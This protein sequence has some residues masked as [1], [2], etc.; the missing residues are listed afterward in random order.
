MSEE[1]KTEMLELSIHIYTE[2]TIDDFFKLLD[3]VDTKIAFDLE[4]TGLDARKD[5]IVLAS[6]CW[7]EEVHII[8][9]D[10]NRIPEHKKYIYHNAKF[11]WQFMYQK[12]GLDLDIYSDTMVLWYNKDPANDVA[13]EDV[14]ET[15]GYPK[16]SFKK[17]FGKKANFRDCLMFDRDR[18]LQYAG[19]DVYVTLKAYKA[20][21][22]YK[23]EPLYDVDMLLIKSVAMSELW[24]I[25]LDIDYFDKQSIILDEQITAL[26]EELIRELGQ[27]SNEKFNINS[28]EQLADAL[29]IYGVP[30]TKKTGSKKG[31]AKKKEIEVKPEEQNDSKKSKKKAKPKEQFAT[32]EDVL[33]KFEDS[34]PVVKKLLHYKALNKLKNSFFDALPELLDDKNMLH[35]SFKT[36]HTATGRFSSSDPNLQQLPNPDKSVKKT[37]IN[38]RCG[39]IPRSGYYFL[40]ADFN[41]IEFRIFASVCKDPNLLQ[42]YAKGLDAHKLAAS[43][44]YNTPY[45]KI[46]KEQRADVKSINFGIIYGK[47]AWGLADQLNIS[48][49]QAQS[50]MD[51]YFKRMPRA[52]QWI[53]RVIKEAMQNGFVISK[54]GRKR[55]IDEINSA[56]N[57]TQKSGERM[58][59]NTSVQSSASDVMRIALVRLSQALEGRDVRM[60]LYIHD[61]FIFE[62][63]E[64]ENIKEICEIIRSAMVFDIEDYL[65]M[66]VEFEKG[67]TWG[68]LAEFDPFNESEKKINEAQEEIKVEII[69]PVEN[70]VLDELGAEIRVEEVEQDILYPSIFIKPS[71]AFSE[72]TEAKLYDILKEYKGSYYLYLCL[73]EDKTILV[74]NRVCRSNTFI[75]KLK[76]LFGDIEYKVF[77]KPAIEQESDIIEGLSKVFEKAEGR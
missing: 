7:D 63:S 31:K 28:P 45:T 42:S 75:D 11:D 51:T 22:E 20:L 5:D 12:Y 16:A 49:E 47:T 60:L 8:E 48:K 50:L 57:Y 14:G 69:D 21:E 10:F 27:E 6:F 67:Y 70:E 38:I 15:L 4:T 29:K 55:Y 19:N 2:E 34:F 73:D 36:C 77:E 61:E 35:C 71:R 54:Y 30:L 65:P 52:Q 37:G 56:D 44:V 13:L 72:D 17:V 32:G 40:G 39:F 24:G 64:K 74:K 41:Q 66:A 1:I 76:G 46:T 18:A 53:N 58:A 68:D 33:K 62:V 3:N 43:L 25:T 9:S 23:Q 59:V 26:K